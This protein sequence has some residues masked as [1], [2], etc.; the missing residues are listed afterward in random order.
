[1]AVKFKILEN[2]VE[3]ETQFSEIRRFGNSVSMAP[4]GITTDK[5]G[6]IQPRQINCNVSDLTE[7]E[8]NRIY[9]P[10]T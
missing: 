10:T 5:G 9:R 7:W 6:S 3:I 4:S 2:G 1:M 8:S